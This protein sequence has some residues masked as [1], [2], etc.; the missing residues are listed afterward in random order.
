MTVEAGS[1]D[2]PNGKD[3]FFV[4]RF[5]ARQIATGCKKKGDC[6]NAKFIS[7]QLVQL[8]YNRNGP[9]RAIV[10]PPLTGALEVEWSQN[11]G[12]PYTV[13]VK[14]A[15]ANSVPYGYGFQV[16]LEAASPPANQRYFVPG[17]AVKLRA[18]FRDGQGRRLG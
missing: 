6:T 3:D 5:V 11:P 7:Q 8:R 14:H 16:S 9:A 15:D 2:R 4:R 17:E 12:S 1:D 10:L 13:A 18:T